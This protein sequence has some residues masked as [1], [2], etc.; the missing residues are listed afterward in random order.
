[1]SY[2]PDCQ[3]CWV[4]FAIN[5][6]VS[7]EVLR[8]PKFTIVNVTLNETL[9]SLT[10][11]RPFET[12]ERTTFVQRRLRLDS[13]QPFMINVTGRSLSVFLTKGVSD[14][15]ALPKIWESQNRTTHFLL[16]QYP[17]T[18]SNYELGTDYV[19]TVVA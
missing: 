13:F 4:Y 17:N 18:Q 3:Y 16:V 12:L 1:M 7:S 15:Q 9:S 8:Q 5:Q 11:I 10:D 19:L 2:E 6:Q 14:Y